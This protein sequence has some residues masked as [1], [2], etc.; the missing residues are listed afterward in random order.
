M[1]HEAAEKAA[2]HLRVPDLR[3]AQKV[4]RYKRAEG[5]TKDALHK[6]LMEGIEKYDMAVWYSHL[7]EQ[8]TL[9]KDAALLKKLEAAVAAKVEEFDKKIATA[10]K[11]EGDVDVRDAMIDRAEYLAKSGDRVR[12]IAAFAQIRKKCHM[13]I[14][15]KL[16]LVF[17]QLKLALFYSDNFEEEK[18]EVSSDDE[19]SESTEEPASKKSATEDKK[20]AR[21]VEKK[22]SDNKRKAKE[23]EEQKKSAITNPHSVSQNLAEAKRLVDEGGDWDR[24]NRLKVYE[25]VH[26]VQIREFEKAAKLFLEAVPTFTTYELMAYEDLVSYCVITCMVSVNRKQMRTELIEGSDIQEQLYSL[27]AMKSYLNSFFNCQYAQFFVSL[28]EMEDVLKND[29]Y[30]ADHTQYYIREMRLA[31]YRQLLASYSSLAIEYM[32]EAFGVSSDFID[33]ELSKFIA[34]GRLSAKIDH[35]AGI[36]ITNRPDLKNQQYR[37]VIK[38]GDSLLNR[39]QK[40]SRVINI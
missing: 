21:G 38:K 30:F 3:L 1:S 14:G 36:V 34:T 13:T 29:R 15:T 37:Q 8:G 17:D 5:A 32:A 31:G 20:D 24:R 33:A 11:E 10:E 40:L 23:E 25:A 6:Q 18:P 26:F 2:D 35:V 16:D 27:T 4:F 12:A 19:K 9:Q 22:K 28:A 7:C 39:V